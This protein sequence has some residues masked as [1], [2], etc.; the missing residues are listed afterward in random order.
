[1]KIIE[2]IFFVLQLNYHTNLYYLCDQLFNNTQ[3]KN[4]Y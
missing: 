1:M 4:A 2:Y 3:S